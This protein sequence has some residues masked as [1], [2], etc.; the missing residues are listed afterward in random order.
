VTET[1]SGQPILFVHGSLA[2]GEETWTNQL[3]LSARWKLLIVDRC[4][5]GLSPDTGRSG[6]DEQAEDIVGLLGP[7]AHLVG[8]SYG[9]TV[10]LLAALRRPQSVRSLT[11]V[12]P[13]PIGLALD[14]A[15]AAAFR[16]RLSRVLLDADRSDPARAYLAWRAALGFTSEP[17]GLTDMDLRCIRASLQEPPPWQASIPPLHRPPFP[18][19]VVLGGWPSE[20]AL[21]QSTGRAFRAVGGRLAERLGGVVVTF[22]ESF[23]N[24]QLLGTPFNQRLERFLEAARQN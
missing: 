15:D 24:P 22:E 3:P 12:E 9:G 5:H 19:L 10:A 2:F 7:G 20:D 11:L 13:N 8:H 1:G 23:H 16:N 14:D 18:V 21:V 6:W 17:E 4:G